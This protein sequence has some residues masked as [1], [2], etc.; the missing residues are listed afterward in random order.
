MGPRKCVMCPCVAWFLRGDGK[1]GNEDCVNY[2]G[3]ARGKHWNAKRIENGNDATDAKGTEEAD[4]SKKR[5]KPTFSRELLQ[6]V[7]DKDAN[8]DGLLFLRDRPDY[9]ALATCAM[10]LS[11]ANTRDACS[12]FM[13]LLCIC[14]IGNMKAFL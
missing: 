5:R 8:G 12:I 6:H 2:G 9:K 3:W 13:L 14:C 11:A 4:P 7:A 10:L 1:C